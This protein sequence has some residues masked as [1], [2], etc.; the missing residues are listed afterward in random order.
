MSKNTPDGGSEKKPTSTHEQKPEHK[1][2]ADPKSNK[3]QAHKPKPEHQRETEHRHKTTDSAPSNKVD[4]KDLRA[5]VEGG[6]D[7]G[8]YSVAGEDK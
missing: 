5:G 3:E 4:I 7:D 2:V 1:D 6:T 8:G